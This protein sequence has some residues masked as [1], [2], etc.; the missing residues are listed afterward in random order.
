MQSDKVLSLVHGT[1]SYTA[2]L[3]HVA[4][5]TQ[6]KAKVDAERSDIGTGLARHPEDTKV[7]VVVE[8]E[9]LAFVDASNSELSLDG[10]DQGRSLEQSTGQGLQGTLELNLT[11]RQFV[12]DCLRISCPLV[13]PRS[14]HDLRRMTATYS[15]PADC[16]LLT[17]LVAR[18]IATMRHPVTIAHKSAPSEYSREL[19][20]RDQDMRVRE[21]AVSRF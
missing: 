19:M 3:L 6:K 11:T 18:S 12:V 10:G 2:K 13:S 8:L 15:F 1:T 20:A 17:S 9:H 7:S 16:W 21:H 14:E 4:A 5:N